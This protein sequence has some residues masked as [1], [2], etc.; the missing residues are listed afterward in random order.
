M[1]KIGGKSYMLESMP[2]H[3]SFADVP[4][5]VFVKKSVEI[6]TNQVAA[7]DVLQNM[8]TWSNINEYFIS[9]LAGRIP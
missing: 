6:L 5:D 9:E 8:Q 4:F 3:F 1:G 2:P 7:V